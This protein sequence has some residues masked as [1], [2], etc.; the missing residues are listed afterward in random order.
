MRGQSQPAFEAGAAMRT[1]TP[2]PLLPVSGGMGIPS[3]AKSKQ[4]EL[5]ARAMVF[6][7]GS[8]TVAVVGVDLLG[9]EDFAGKQNLED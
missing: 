5:T 9:A 2:N 6:R 4:G 7:A 1:I 3:P 8:V